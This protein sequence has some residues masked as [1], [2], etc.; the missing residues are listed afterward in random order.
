[1]PALADETPFVRFVGERKLFPSEEVHFLVLA[2][3]HL[4]NYL[5]HVEILIRTIS[6]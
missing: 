6:K 3:K 4:A 1:M 5:H 2:S